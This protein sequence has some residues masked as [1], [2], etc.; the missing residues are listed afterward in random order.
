MYMGYRHTL[1]GYA[2]GQHPMK[3]KGTTNSAVGKSGNILKRKH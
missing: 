2:V 1:R 3:K